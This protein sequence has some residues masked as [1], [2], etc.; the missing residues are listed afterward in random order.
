ML[1]LGVGEGGGVCLMVIELEVEVLLCD[2]FRCLFGCEFGDWEVEV[3]MEG[4]E[5]VEEEG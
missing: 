2:C 3:D 4:V 5:E 1:L